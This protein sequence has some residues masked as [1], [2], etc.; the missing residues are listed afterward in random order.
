MITKSSLK[1][2]FFLIFFTLVYRDKFLLDITHIFILFHSSIDLFVLFIFF[3]DLDYNFNTSVS[4]FL[5]N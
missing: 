4:I 3:Y 2:K 5:R 1:L